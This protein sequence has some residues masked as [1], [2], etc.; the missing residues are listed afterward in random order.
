[1]KIPFK[2]WATVYV[3]MGLI[4]LVSGLFFVKFLGFAFLFFFLAY[5]YSRQ[6]VEFTADKVI[7]SLSR[8]ALIEI[9]KRKITGISIEK[10]KI[11]LTVRTTGDKTKKYTVAFGNFSAENKE[12]LINCFQQLQNEPAGVSR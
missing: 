7:L 1:M 4:T 12:T 8:F 3:V 5:G 6:Y 2:N 9:P 11:K 10:R